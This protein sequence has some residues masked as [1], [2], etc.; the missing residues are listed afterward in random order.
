[1]LLLMTNTTVMAST[2]AGR[3]EQS[4]EMQSTLNL[5][6]GP[7]FLEYQCTGTGCPTYTIELRDADGVLVDSDTGQPSASI[8]GNILTSGLHTLSVTFEGDEHPIE[9]DASWPIGPGAE[10]V[11][12]TGTVQNVSELAEVAFV[13]PTESN[14]TS[15]VGWNGSLDADDQ[16][17]WWSLEPHAGD[18]HEIEAAFMGTSGR[19]EGI[20]LNSQG[21]PIES[22][23][24]ESVQGE[25]VLRFRAP[26]ESN[27][28]LIGVETDD[29]KATHYT[30]Q[31]R[32]WNESSESHR[33]E[34]QG[35]DCT[36]DEQS[37][38]TAVLEA[39]HPG[40][41]G[42]LP[43]LDSVWGREESLTEQ[44]IQRLFTLVDPFD[45]AGDGFYFDVE[46]R[47]MI[48]ITASREVDVRL[49]EIRLA[50][51]ASQPVWVKFELGQL[52]KEAYE[53][54]TDVEARG[55][56]IILAS[57]EITVVELQVRSES[58]GDAGME[59]G[60][61]PDQPSFGTFDT[62]FGLSPVSWSD[63]LGGQLKAG[64]GD[65]ADVVYLS[66]D[67]SKQGQYL[68]AYV[69]VGHR[70]VISLYTLKGDLIERKTIETDPVT[71]EA[72]V[73]FDVAYLVVELGD[74]E[75]SDD[76]QWT[77]TMT[78]TANDVVEPPDLGYY[79]V[80]FHAIIGIVL[81]L[82]M[83]IVLFTFRHHTPV[84]RNMELEG[85]IEMLMQMLS[86]PAANSEHHVHLETALEQLSAATWTEVQPDGAT[87]IASLSSDVLELCAF[88]LE[89]DDEKEHWIV[90]ILPKVAWSRAG[91]RLHAPVGQAP[92]IMTAHPKR[93]FLEDEV[94]LGNLSA[95]SPLWLTLTFVTHGHEQLDIEISG[96]IEG[97]STTVRVPSVPSRQSSSRDES[98]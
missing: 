11:D 31:H 38:C 73:D 57:A 41:N 5:N 36:G 44:P 59:R 48:R 22:W 90:G 75:V 98:E 32:I 19:L 16:A 72:K 68:E 18:L 67:E 8:E 4:Y 28:V 25:S 52:T 62:T 34:R 78:I 82:P 30:V 26:L 9:V 84:G 77:A 80:I 42:T 93:L 79:G 70:A 69:I 23:S 95:D 76:V 81:I 71:I 66:F 14:S 33:G 87:A 24:I 63:T 45:P 92:S 96:E 61:G 65:R 97:E 13:T 88:S 2:T 21:S 35:L 60:D 83:I 7:F 51:D 10:E 29:P 46:S 20:V 39:R 91:C 43:R 40:S 27:Q 94:M 58:V 54:R 15:A 53:H 56:L 3:N 89:R 49:F 50:D 86:V 74:Q 37:N 55:L 1:M 47:E 85:R 6:E 64:I 12:R 17:D